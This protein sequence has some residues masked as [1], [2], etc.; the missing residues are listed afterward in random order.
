MW[1]EPLRCSIDQG[2]HSTARRRGVVRSDRL[3]VLVGSEPQALAAD[4]R[5]PETLPPPPGALA[6]GDR[7][8]AVAPAAGRGGQ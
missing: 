5:V 4:L 1:I 2:S 3:G 8:H 7:H 6:I